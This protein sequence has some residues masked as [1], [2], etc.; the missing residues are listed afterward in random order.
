MDAF[1]LRP[2]RRRTPAEAR[3]YLQA[4]I[5]ATEYELAWELRSI[6]LIPDLPCLG[7]RVTR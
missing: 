3:A 6:G 4:G 7:I 1:G 2:P 5:D